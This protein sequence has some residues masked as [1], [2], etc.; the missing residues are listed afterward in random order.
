MQFQALQLNLYFFFIKLYRKPLQPPY[1]HFVIV[2]YNQKFNLYKEQI[3]KMKHNLEGKCANATPK[4]Q[5][6]K[7]VERNMI[8]EDL[9]IINFYIC[10]H[11]II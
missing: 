5:C 6:V 8:L 7:E 1:Q 4:L 9:E 11:N 10:M 3:V 2:F